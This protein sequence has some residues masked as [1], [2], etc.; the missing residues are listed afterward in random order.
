MDAVTKPIP[1]HLVPSN[2]IDMTAIATFAVAGAT[3]LLAVVTWRLAG[4]AKLEAEATKRLAMEAKTDRLLAWRP[5]L[6]VRIDQE[7][8]GVSQPFQIMRLTNAG[9]GP[10]LSCR[11]VRWTTDHNGWWAT[12]SVGVSAA[13]TSEPLME[14]RHGGTRV[15]NDLFAPGPDTPS[16]I[17]AAIFCKDALGRRYRFPMTIGERSVLEPD[18]WPDEDNPNEVVLPPWV[19]CVELWL[20]EPPTTTL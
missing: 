8:L 4:Q 20:A 3:I 11:Y 17:V 14:I 16:E 7:P 12:P 9:V 15:P 10:A 6:N 1:V 18:V 5:L 19:T 2:G 13:G